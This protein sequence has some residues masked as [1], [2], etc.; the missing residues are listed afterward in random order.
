MPDPDEQDEDER[1]RSR[2]M[3]GPSVEIRPLRDTADTE[4]CAQLMSASEP[5]I[6]LRRSYAD[7]LRILTDTSR[8]IHLAQVDEQPVGF[9]I[10]QMHGAFVG[11]IQTVAIAPRWRDRGIGT[12][13]IV[14]AEQR[15]L[16]ETPNVFL[17]VS[18]FNTRALELYLRLGYEQVGELRDYIVAGHSEILLRKTTGPLN[19]FGKS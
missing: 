11:Y 12:R 15:I 6:T 9:V 14:F 7:S 13:L 5:W 10:L 4:W 17:C 8:E 1:E 2:H 18:S 16:T 19:D 3:T